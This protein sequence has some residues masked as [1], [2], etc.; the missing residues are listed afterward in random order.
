MADI[1][2][3]LEA[4]AEEFAGKVNLAKAEVVESLMA[5]IKDKTPEEALEVLSGFNMEAAMGMKL[6]SAF[7]AYD[8]GVVS[9]LENTFTTTT[10]SEATLQTLLNNTKGMITDEVTRHLSKVS[11]Q[12][13]IDGIAVN[14]SPAEVIKTID[15]VIPNINTLVNTSFNQFSNSTTNLMAAKAPTNTRYIYIGPLDSKTRLTCS[16][17]IAFSGAE[18]RTRDEIFGLFGDM[19]NEIF[20]CR[21]K[22][23]QMSDSPE[24]QG[25][26]YN[27]R[28]YMDKRTSKGVPK[29][30]Q[31]LDQDQFVKYRKIA[32][33]RSAGRITQDEFDD[34]VKRFK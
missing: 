34:K 26:N 10:L 3:K 9:M 32:Q 31:D 12:N 14:K 13:I 17:K 23:E 29:Y 30:I 11:I 16:D 8:S 24:D 2:D 15:E 4:I 22:W 6:S 5:F 18:G 20:N 33:D 28:Y 7:V 25:Y 27:E 21:H 19:N 1:H